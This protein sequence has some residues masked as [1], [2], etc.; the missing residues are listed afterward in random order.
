MVKVISSL[1]GADN[2]RLGVLTIYTNHEGG[3]LVYRHK[4]TVYNLMW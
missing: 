2:E 3:N 1:F 4:T